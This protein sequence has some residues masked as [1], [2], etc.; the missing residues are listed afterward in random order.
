MSVHDELT[1]ELHDAMR[2]KDRRRSSA[3]RQVEAEVSVAKSAPGFTGAVD[4]GLYS[5]VIGTYVKK[6]GKARKEY[7][8]LGDRGAAHAEK[9]AFEIEYLSRWLPETLGEEETRA[10]V[11][12]AIASLGADDVKMT[13]RVIGHLMK[14]GAD[15]DGGTVARL[16]KEELGS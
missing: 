3:V 4:D 14:S 6:I 8:G 15:L 12:E 9:L 13:G 10:M 1:A 5:K 2:A 11:Q 7:E 16:V